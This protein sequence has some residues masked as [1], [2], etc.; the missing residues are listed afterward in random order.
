MKQIETLIPD[1]HKLLVEGVEVSDEQAKAFGDK[2][3]QLVQTRL[4]RE[5]REGTLR[6]SNI[7]KPNRQ[8]WY[9][10]NRP[11]DGEKLH[12]NS[13]MKFLYGD[14]IEELLLF[15][16]EMA[17]HTVEGHQDELDIDGIKGHRDAVVD[18]VTT[19]FK[20]A[21]P[22]SFKKFEKG[23][24]PEQDAFG[25]IGQINNYIH[26]GKDDPIVLDKDRGAFF[27]LQK[28]T[29]E[30]AL[31]IHK[32]SPVDPVDIIKYKKEMVKQPE[33]PERCYEDEKFGESGNRKL[34]LN[35]SYCPFKYLC[36]ENLQGY[37]YSNGPVWLTVVENEPKV[38]RIDREGNTYS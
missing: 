16:S 8:L 11:N 35:C 14:V 9:E 24:T 38:P 6:M 17:G 30:M 1:I 37:A 18:G 33:P 22:F 15:L 26:A 13:L 28:V 10:V 29:G 3:A 25:Y 21:S 36:W 34:G 4:K 2:M 20:S 23:L 19:D 32:K 12:P 27:A 31:D 7:G 5:P